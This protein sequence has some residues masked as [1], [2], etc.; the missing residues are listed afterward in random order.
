MT[1]VVSQRWWERDQ[2]G[3]PTFLVPAMPWADTPQAQRLCYAGK[4]EDQARRLCISDRRRWRDR[5]RAAGDA[6][7]LPT[8]AAYRTLIDAALRQSDGRCYL[9]GRTLAWDRWMRP[10]AERQL[11]GA[12]DR[13]SYPSFDHEADASSCGFT[14]RVCAWGLNDAKS[15][16][17][18]TDF[19]ALCEEV[20][21][22][23][24][25]ERLR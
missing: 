6:R 24:R 14:L 8:I 13:T 1:R 15:D 22:H 9:S 2:V 3:V 10:H 19:L 25:P 4:L 11:L 23:H 5:R 20:L 17:C 16:R 21:R 18:L 7:P 12:I